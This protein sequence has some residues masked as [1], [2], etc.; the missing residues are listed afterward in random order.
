[1]PIIIEASDSELK[2]PFY[3]RN[4]RVADQ[5]SMFHDTSP[6]ILTGTVNAYRFEAKISGVCDSGTYSID[7]LRQ[8]KNVQ[9]PIPLNSPFYDVTT[10]EIEIE[11]PTQD[12]WKIRPKSFGSACIS[13]IHQVTPTTFN[14]NLMLISHNKMDTQTHQIRNQFAEA[15]SKHGLSKLT[16]KVSTLNIQFNRL[17]VASHELTTL[18]KLVDSF[19]LL[20]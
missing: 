1:M 20:R 18:I 12:H 16:F 4:Q 2:S 15:L 11:N 14:P 10:L 13:I 7:G 5:W 17:I 6:G 3:A 9:G 19:L 8:I